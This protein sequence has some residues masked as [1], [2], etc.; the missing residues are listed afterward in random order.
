MNDGKFH[1]GVL[2]RV[3]STEKILD[4]YENRYLR[5]GCPANWINYANTHR[6]GLADE[7][8]GVFAHVKQDDPRLSMICDDGYP[9]NHRRSLW[10]KLMSDGTV[11]ARYVFSCLVPAICFYSIDVKDAAKHFGIEGNDDKWLRADLQPYYKALG[12]DVAESSVLV[13]W[14]PGELIEELRLEIPKVIGAAGN[15]DKRRFDARN[16]LTVK[17]VNYDLD[18]DKEF[19]ELHPYD[20][21]FR[22]RMEYKRQREARM[23]IPNAPFM[24]DPVY[25]PEMYYDNELSVPV[26]G[27][28]SYARVVPASKCK[29]IQFDNFSEDLST[30]T[31]GAYDERGENYQG[32]G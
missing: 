28:Q 18:I 10:N 8:E 7:Y 11:Y 22:K 5:F 24:R 16:A 14:R 30:W 27:V 25:R 19:W 3:G 17:Y 20:E 2:I 15:V 1:C 6:D 32:K 26:P 21:L 29:M 9:L 12:I 4:Q 13:V 31:V 23:I